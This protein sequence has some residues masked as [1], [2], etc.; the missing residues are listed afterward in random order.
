MT[1]TEEIEQAIKESNGNVRDALNVSLARNSALQSALTTATKRLEKFELDM[2]EIVNEY[3]KQLTTAQEEN[4]T[5]EKHWDDCMD[6]VR[7]LPTN[8]PLIEKARKLYAEW[9][10]YYDAQ[11][12][13]NGGK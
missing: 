12:A 2:A 7:E 8:S 5:L 6:V 1:P 9:C 11:S 4:K 13:L 3:D 10:D